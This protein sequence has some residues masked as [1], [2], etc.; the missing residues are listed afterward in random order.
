M[1]PILFC[2]YVDGL[3]NLLTAA[4]IGCLICRVFVG[5]LA[6]EDDIVLLP[7]NTGAM[8]NIM[9]AI[10]DSFAKEYDLRLVP[11]ATVSWS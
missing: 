6:Y 5:F 7:P 9:F 8:R 3:L 11:T 4:Q 2:I 1:N 10:C